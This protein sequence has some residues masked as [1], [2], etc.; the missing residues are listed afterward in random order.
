MYIRHEGQH[1]QQQAQEGRAHRQLNQLSSSSRLYQARHAPSCRLGHIQ[2]RHGGSY[3]LLAHCSLPLQALLDLC[4][5]SAQPPQLVL[6]I[7]GLLLCTLCALLGRLQPGLQRTQGR[8]GKSGWVAGL[9]QACRRQTEVHSSNV[10]KLLPNTYRTSHIQAGTRRN[11]LIKKASSDPSNSSLNPPSHPP[12]FSACCSTCSARL[13]SS[14]V[15]SCLFSEL[16]S[17]R[18]TSAALC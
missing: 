11:L 13:A 16:A 2:R 5:L 10:I 7:R 3:L 12:T 14:A 1:S 18:A 15:L 17:A 6:H 9:Y 8:A 4:I